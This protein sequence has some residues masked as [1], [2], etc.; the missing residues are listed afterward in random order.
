MSHPARRRDDRTTPHT[1]GGRTPVSRRRRLPGTGL[2]EATA[3]RLLDGS[4]DGPPPLP[5]LL[6]AA[7]APGTAAEL[8]GEAAARAAFQSSVHAAP[9]PVR[10]RTARAKTATAIVTAKI[11]AAVVLTAGTAG[12]VALATNSYSAHPQ[13]T[14]G[15]SGPGTTAVR[16]V[17]PR[18]TPT[19]TTVPSPETP[20]GTA[21]SGGSAEPDA[22]GDRAVSP[23]GPGAAPPVRPGAAPPGPVER[24][25]VRCAPETTGGTAT[26]SGET[27]QAGDP[28]PGNGNGNGDKPEKEKTDNGN[29]STKEKTNNGNGAGKTKADNGNGSDEQKTNNGNGTGSDKQKT[30][31]GKKTESTSDD[32][33][34]AGKKEK[35]GG[36]G[37]SKQANVGK[38]QSKKKTDAGTTA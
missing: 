5:Q 27:G 35:A 26:P 22:D 34:N 23:A 21:E 7:T 8:Q 25:G 36:N 12:G 4:G 2:S 16:G 6:A 11:I 29:G 18:G 38:G 33:E 13:E 28:K 9:G 19:A 37:P 15:V 20:D 24:C 1:S 30:D 14:P 32:V 31:N 10:P 17:S 3:R